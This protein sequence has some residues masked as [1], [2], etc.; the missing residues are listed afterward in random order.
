MQIVLT[1]GDLASLSASTRNEILQH[2]S[3]AIGGPT[4][5]PPSVWVLERGWPTFR[6]PRATT[7]VRLALLWSEVAGGIRPENVAHSV[8]RILQRWNVTNGMCP[9]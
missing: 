9:V 5:A 2:V 7:S 4:A 1:E 8:H 3:Q 6:F